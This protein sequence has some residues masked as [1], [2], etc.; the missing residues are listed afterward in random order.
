MDELIDDSLADLALFVR[1]ADSGGFTAAAR[2]TG[3]PQ[4]TVSRRIA[5]L[6]KRFKTQLFYRTTRRVTL[7]DVGKRIY[8]HARL[9]LDQ[10]E[11]AGATFAALQAEPAGTLRIAAPVILGQ[12]FLG[13][14]VADFMERYPKVSIRLELTARQLDLVE[15]G[16]DIV[17][18]VGR[19]PDSSLRL[20]YV[21]STNTG[22]Y[23]TP[24]Y[25]A[26][27]S[28]IDNPSD[29]LTHAML[30]LGLSLEPPPLVLQRGDRSEAIP[31]KARMACNDTVS[32]KQAAMLNLG[33]VILPRFYA[34]EAVSN[35][36]LVEILPE[37]KTASVP[38]NALTLPSRRELPTVRLFLKAMQERL[39]LHLT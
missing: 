21:G 37:W 9:M 18:R 38:V 1:V 22:L 31:L 12:S 32:L 26:N 23:A 34:S 19:L 17:L 35:H 14:I 13:G 3:T 2:L 6:E 4:A 8:N 25:L 33:V 28:P 5:L 27:A 16:V 36:E 20:N 15:E 39:K 30:I 7:T 29:L 11:A 10:A 24:H